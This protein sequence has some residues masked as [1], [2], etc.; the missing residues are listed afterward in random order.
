MLLV[1]DAGNT[2]TV[3]G[4]YRGDA[5]VSHWRMSSHS[6]RTADEAWI[7]LRGWCGSQ[8]LRTED[9]RDA[10]ISSVVPDLTGL[11]S[12]MAERHLSVR[13]LV[14]SS[15]T[16]TGIPIGYDSPRT[17]GA[18]RICDAVGGVA[19]YGAPLV[20]V[21]F[22]TAITFDAISDRGEYLGG[23]ICLGLRG[24]AREL[25][26]VAAKLPRVDLAFPAAAIGRNTES[27]IQSGI[28]WGTVAM[29]DGLIGRIGAEL[30]RP[31]VTAVATGGMAGLI[32]SQCGRIAHVEPFLTLEGMRL[33]HRR[34]ASRTAP[35]T[36]GV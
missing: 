24:A 12:D 36:G 9:I 31:G 1:I 15:D 14:V 20:V 25:H 34:A 4:L 18:D 22:G 16:D 11:F 21:D 35:Q 29:V 6:G 5:L 26:R 13:P 23:L 28:L 2:E 17:V 19:K 30:G 33:I 3:F 27:S 7:L 32:A 8:G 10:V